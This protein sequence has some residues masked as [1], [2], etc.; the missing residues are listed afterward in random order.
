MQVYEVVVFHSQSRGTNRTRRHP[1]P[2]SRKM[3]TQHSAL[4]DDTA[5]SRGDSAPRHK[6][7]QPRQIPW[8]YGRD[9]V[10][11][12]AIDPEQ[13]FVYWE[14]RDET[15]EHARTQLG[16]LGSRAV[17]VLRVY[18]TTGR[19]FDGANAHSSFDQ[20]VQRSDRQWFCTVGKAAS[21]AHVEMG[22]RASDGRFLKVAR[23][24]RIDFPRGEPA[25]ARAPEWMRVVASTGDIVSR[26]TPA[27]AD[28]GSRPGPAP[29]HT[30]VDGTVEAVAPSATLSHVVTSQQLASIEGFELVGLEPG[31]YEVERN[32]YEID[33]GWQTESKDPSV[34]YRSWTSHWEESGFGTSSWETS[35]SESSWEAGPFSYPTE[36]IVPVAER[37][38]GPAQVYRSGE[39]TRVL[40]GPWQVIIRGIQ[41]HASRRVL[42]RWEV[43]RSWISVSSRSVDRVAPGGREA[44]NGSSSWAGASERHLLSSSELRLRGASEIFMVGASERRLGGASET[45]FLGASQWAARG[46]SERRLLGASEWRLAGASERRLAGASER[47]LAGGSERRLAGASERH[48]GGASERR[49]GAS[50]S[51]LGAARPK[52]ED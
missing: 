31:S 12:T 15:I 47:R 11:A 32:E 5:S 7:V 43:H 27:L 17:L 1:C 52:D 49:Q 36:V 16:A 4:T 2:H 41:A 35:P 48:V 14:I 26:E 29:A 23:S 6:L 10:T 28:A 40:H 37:F 20:D 34:V 39:E 42:A 9:R 25:P 3:A 18:D 50:E 45:R 30:G 19:I 21:S 24:G 13:L 38:E 46:A 22:L 8:G 51:R 44:I 33:S